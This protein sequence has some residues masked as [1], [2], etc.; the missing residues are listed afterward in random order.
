ML[1]KFESL[2]ILSLFILLETWNCCFSS[3]LAQSF[4]Q[5]S[6][7]L[8]SSLLFFVYQYSFF[9]CFCY[10]INDEFQKVFEKWNPKIVLCR[11]NYCSSSY[12]LSTVHSVRLFF[13]NRTL[14]SVAVGHI[15]CCLFLFCLWEVLL[16]PQAHLTHAPNYHP[17][18]ENNEFAVAQS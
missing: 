7:A 11:V 13:L 9:F 12:V 5:F 17:E 2:D 10:S 3:N 16:R 6:S 1:S 15:P 4:A 8:L 14:E 18:Q